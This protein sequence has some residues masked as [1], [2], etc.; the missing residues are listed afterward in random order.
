MATLQEMQREIGQKRGL[1]AEK[2][3]AVKTAP[4]EQQQGI[5]EEINRI[6]ADLEPMHQKIVQQQTLDEIERRNNEDIERGNKPAPTSPHPSGDENGRRHT[7]SLGEMMVTEDRYKRQLEEFRNSS[8]QNKSLELEFPFKTVR[9]WKATLNESTLTGYDRVPGIVTLGEQVPH[10]AD[11]LAQGETTQPTVRYVR[12]NSYANAAAAVAENGLKPEAT[13]DLQEADGPVRKIGVVARVTD[14]M[15]ADFPT[16]RDYVNQRLPFMVEQSEDNALLNGNGTAPNLRG[17]LQTSGILSGGTN[18]QAG[19]EFVTDCLLRAQTNIRSQSFFEPTGYVLNPLDWQTIRLMK[20]GDGTNSAKFY[21]WGPPSDP[22]PA[23]IWGLPV[24]QTVTIAAKT[25]LTGAFRLGAQIFYRQGITI[26][27]TNSDGNDF[28]YNRI[29][30]RCE[31][32]LALCV[33]R[34]QGF[35]KSTLS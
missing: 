11:L 33:Y 23:T 9:E 18:D 25:A 1:L 34:P 19:G 2:L 7:K 22:G 35:A 32:R 16:T 10:V 14:E 28:Q 24:V 6:N 4:E 31:I 8:S 29:A 27:M 12:E 15:F 5:I 17:I 21:V 3:K 20:S 30:I 26:D 13:F